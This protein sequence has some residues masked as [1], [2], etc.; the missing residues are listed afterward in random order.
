MKK[1]TVAFL[2]WCS[3][4]PL[5]SPAGGPDE[6]QK[7]EPPP[8]PS[9]LEQY[10]E[11]RQR[12]GSGPRPDFVAVVP[13]VDESGFRE[14]VWNVEYELAN[15]LSAELVAVRNWKVVPFDAV[16]ELAMEQGFAS[17][18]QA[19]AI[20]RKLGADFVIMGLLQDYD[21]RRLSVGDP[22]VGGYKSYSAVAQM[23]VEI[24]QVDDGSAIGQAETLRNLTDRDVGL[25]LLGKPREQDL[26]FASLKEVEFGSEEFRQTLLGQ[27]TVEAIGELVHKVVAAFEPEGLVFK[28]DAPEVIAVYSEDIY[29]NIGSAHGIRP[30]LRFF[31]YPGNERI[32]AEGLDPEESVALVEVA[33]IIST[34][35][36]SLRVI[37]TTGE[38]KAG[39]RLELAE[40]E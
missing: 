39:D 23:R 20:G 3:C 2:L 6:W 30:R 34:R 28:G 37:R 21:M 27:A 35:L 38:I 40:G 36:A 18:E 22:L 7:S 16:A 12:Y 19:L 4:A 31:V 17:H 25:D 26:Q 24:A 5:T 32:K 33:E 9:A 11:M 14:G 8:P 1:W 29:A 10:L 13:F 15:M